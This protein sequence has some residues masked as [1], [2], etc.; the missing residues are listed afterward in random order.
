MRLPTITVLGALLA[1]LGVQITIPTGVLAQV[2]AVDGR[3]T[4]D[5]WTPSSRSYERCRSPG[6][7]GSSSGAREAGRRLGEAIREALE[8]LFAPAPAQPHPQRPR[9]PTSRTYDPSFD[10][11]A[12][13][14]DTE[15]TIC[16]SSSLSLLDRQLGGEYVRLLLHFDRDRARGDRPHRNAKALQQRRWLARRDAC[17]ARVSCISDLYRRRIAEFRAESDRL[18]LQERLPLQPKRTQEP[19]NPP[20]RPDRRP[21]Y[22]CNSDLAKHYFDQK[23]QCEDRRDLSNGVCKELRDSDPRQS[24]VCYVDTQTVYGACLEQLTTVYPVEIRRCPSP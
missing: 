12:D 9:I 8:S 14:N 6:D 2:P 16:H 19:S 4:G 5:C 13:T 1:T 17:G 7:D 15:E 23:R 24:A 21:Q 3:G 10:C 11:Q 22:S 20:S 18:D